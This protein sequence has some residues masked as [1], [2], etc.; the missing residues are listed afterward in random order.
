[1]HDYLTARMTCGMICRIAF[2]FGAS[3]RDKNAPRRF[4][5]KLI[6]NPTLPK[7]NLFCRAHHL[8]ANAADP[9]FQPSAIIAKPG[10]L[11]PDSLRT[12]IV[13]TCIPSVIAGMQ[14]RSPIQIGIEAIATEAAMRNVS[15]RPSSREE[16][17]RVEFED[18]MNVI[19]MV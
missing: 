18:I 8:S 5:Q 10:L 17:K 15:C 19:E 16:I 2:L 7:C 1:M 12:L 3:A 14:I 9:L 6:T 11:W 4:S 13:S